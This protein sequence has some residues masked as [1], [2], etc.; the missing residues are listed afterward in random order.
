[1]L[2]SVQQVEQQ[3]CKLATKVNEE[4]FKWEVATDCFCGDKCGCS[5]DY[6]FDSEVM[7]FIKEA[8]EAKI[9]QTLEVKG[10]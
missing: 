9:T 4:V 8:I 6:R 2:L 1:M 10:K 3:L 5:S 7:D